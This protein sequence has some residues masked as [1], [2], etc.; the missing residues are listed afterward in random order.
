M[1]EIGIEAWHGGA[2]CNDLKRLKAEYG[3]KLIFAGCV[4]PQVTDTG[5]ATEE[6]IRADVR[7]AI[8]TLGNAYTQ[9]EGQFRSGRGSLCRQVDLLCEFGLTP[10]QRMKLES[11]EDTTAADE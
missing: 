8:D 4:D 5:R 3:D 1:V 7:R 6:E 2:P 10:N 11:A 9:V